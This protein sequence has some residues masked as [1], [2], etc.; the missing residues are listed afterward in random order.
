MNSKRLNL[1]ELSLHITEE[2]YRQSSAL[3]HSLIADYDRKGFDVISSPRESLSSPSLTKGSIV[4]VLLTGAETEFGNK[5]YVADVDK[6]SDKE[7]YI[8]DILASFKNTYN[9]IDDIPV[10]YIAEACKEASYYP[11]RKPE[12]N[13]ANIKESCR[14]YYKVLSEAGTREIITTDLYEKCLGCAYAIKDNRTVSKYFEHN[15]PF[16]PDIDH[17]Y[18]LKFITELEGTEFAIMPDSIYVNHNT[19]EIDIIDLKTGSCKEYNF[20]KTNFLMFGYSIQARLYWRVL[21]KILDDNGFQYYKLN[22]FKFVIVNEDSLTPILWEFDSCDVKG[23]IYTGKNNQIELHDP[24]ELGIEIKQY[25]ETNATVP[26]YINLE[27]TNNINNLL[28]T[29]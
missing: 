28:K 6:L 9:S 22:N 27:G 17:H 3:H 12:T 13:V 10:S 16:N 15:N 19:K 7:K 24:V 11:N 26:S 20:Y 14:D 23:T 1:E 8:L 2:E 21:R 4:D 29:L 5:Y 25:M 18:Q